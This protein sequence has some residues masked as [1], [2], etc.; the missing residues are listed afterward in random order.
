MEI[1]DLLAAALIGTVAGAVDVIPMI[2]RKLDKA[3]CISAFTHYF[4]LGLVIPFVSW[5]L[6]PWLTGI[7]VSFLSA[8]PV[9]VL[10]FAKDRKAII[11]MILFSVVLGACIGLAGATFIG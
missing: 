3:S 7:I 10:V 4:V 11:P 8:M 6:E 2:I 5:N 9:M 1:N